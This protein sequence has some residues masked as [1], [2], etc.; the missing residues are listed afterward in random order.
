MAFLSGVH[1]YYRYHRKLCRNTEV[2]ADPVLGF[3]PLLAYVNHELCHT[4]LNAN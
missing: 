3:I 1:T 2:L 4:P